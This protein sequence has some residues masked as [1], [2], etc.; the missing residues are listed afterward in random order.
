MLFVNKTITDLNMGCKFIKKQQI[1]TKVLCFISF[2][3]NRKGILHNCCVREK[4]RL[5]F[6][7]HGVPE[8]ANFISLLFLPDLFINPIHIPFLNEMHFEQFTNYVFINAITFLGIVLV[9][10]ISKGGKQIV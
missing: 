3:F 9:C 4:E 8:E 10:P 1:Q 7:K 2:L 5:L 6:V